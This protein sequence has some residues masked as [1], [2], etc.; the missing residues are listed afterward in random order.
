MKVFCFVKKKKYTVFTFPPSTDTSPDLNMN[1]TAFTK[2]YEST[3]VIHLVKSLMLKGCVIIL[4]IACFD[5]LLIK[6]LG[7]ASRSTGSRSAPVQWAVTLS[8]TAL[9]DLF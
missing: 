6:K 5:D 8:I 7:D 9:I 2:T 1:I 3:R 4:N